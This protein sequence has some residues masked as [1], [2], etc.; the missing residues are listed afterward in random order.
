MAASKK[1]DMTDTLARV[2]KLYEA[3]HV[4]Y[5]RTGCEYIPEGHFAEAGRVMEAIR[6]SCP[7]VSDMMGGA[8]LTRKGAAWDDSR[9]TEHHAIIPTVRGP[10]G[11]VLP[12]AERKVYELICSRYVLQFL[13]DCEYEE[14]IAEFES[15]GEITEKFRAVGRAVI[16]IGWQGW[17]KQDE[18]SGEKEHKET[19]GNEDDGR[20]RDGQTIP[21]VRRGEVGTIHAAPEKRM[22]RAPKPFTYHG[23]LA[24]MN[25]VYAYVED[26]AIRAKLK[27]VQ[28]IGTEA[29]QESI[30][31]TLFERG[32][33]EKKKKAI[34]PTELGRLLISLL[35]SGK[36]RVMIR[37]DMTALW[38][39]AID[40]IQAGA[41]KASLESFVA[42]V[43]SMVEDIVSE[44]LVIPS[45][46]PLVPG[47]ERLHKCLTE[48]CGGFLRRIA[49]PGKSA[50]FSCPLCHATFNDAGGSPVPKKTRKE[51]FR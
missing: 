32:Y 16:N 39:V 38:E 21:S 7:P 28:G 13:G 2:Q 20:E 46:I 22:T 45:E 4:T 50:F 42:E 19:E 10:R 23:L 9:T 41:G 24:A 25:N 29:T 47:M 48:G 18:K 43:A 5:P 3:G 8:D 40:E 33:M 31:S 26:P 12:D 34:Y 15:G 51:G 11:G 30:L 1:Y 36:S 27:E 35:E 44:R 6:A 37:P 49:K 17:D 14:T